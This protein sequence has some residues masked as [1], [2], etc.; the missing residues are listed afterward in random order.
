[1]Y[2]FILFFA[3]ALF[4]SQFLFQQK[5][6][7]ECGASWHTSLIFTLYTSVISFVVML[8]LNGFRLH[9]SLFSLAV[10][11]IYAIVN[12]LYGY[13]SIKAFSVVNLSVYSVLAMLGGMLLP[14]LYGIVFA[15]ESITAGKVICCILI[16]GSLLMTTSHG[17]KGGYFYYCSVFVLNGLAGVLSAI[18]QGNPNAVGSIDFMILNRIVTVCICVVILFISGGSTLKISGKAFIYSVFYALFCGFGNLFVLISLKHLPASVQYPII[19][20]GTI[21]FSLLISIIRK[22]TVTRRN[23]ISAVLALSA[24][25]LILF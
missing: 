2:Y 23:V 22:E 17:K 15:D 6:N 14:F 8:I 13:M 25:I 12:I 5:F 10:A 11:F 9:V 7:G 20:G 21:V 16:T 24:T 19:T 4:A 1:M 3:A 18:H